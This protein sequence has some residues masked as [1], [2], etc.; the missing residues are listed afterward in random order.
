MENR[1]SI[2]IDCPIEAVFR[3]AN[4]QI[5]EWSSIVVADKVLDEGQ[6]GVGTR[7]Q[8]ITEEQGHRMVFEGVVTCYEP[9]YKSAVNLTGKMFDIETEFQFEQTFGKTRVTQTAKV[10]GK[11]FFGLY[12]FLFGW[13]MKRGH[14]R[15]SNNEL[16]NLKRF[17]E[18]QTAKR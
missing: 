15:A 9:P 8:T 3:I 18:E 6:E 13:L 12:M 5:A 14:C 4:E 2:E 11:G 7:F 10:R 17:C 16:E 1:I